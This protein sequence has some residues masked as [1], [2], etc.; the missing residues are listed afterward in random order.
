M[1]VAREAAGSS[2]T[3]AGSPTLSSD[4]TP[5][6]EEV[7]AHQVKRARA[8]HIGTGVD[9]DVPPAA[10]WRVGGLERRPD[11]RD[12]LAVGDHLVQRK[13]DATAALAASYVDVRYMR[14]ARGQTGDPELDGD[15]PLARGQRDGAGRL[16]RVDGVEPERESLRAGRG[17]VARRSFLSRRR[18]EG[19]TRLIAAGRERSNREQRDGAPGRGFAPCTW[20]TGAGYWRRRGFDPGPPLAA[21]LGGGSPAGTARPGGVWSG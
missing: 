16:R 3:S 18:R 8:L 14:R 6:L 12:A 17:R 21:L 11:V 15:R 20:H 7:S 10:G 13:G 1:S 19:R 2:T 9:H 4:V 5:I